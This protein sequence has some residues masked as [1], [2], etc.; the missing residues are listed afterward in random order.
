MRDIGATVAGRREWTTHVEMIPWPKTL[1]RDPSEVKVVAKR[2]GKGCAQL[3]SCRAH[4]F[5]R[6]DLRERRPGIWTRK[7]G[8]S[9]G[10]GW[11]KWVA[12]VCGQVAR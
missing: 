1:R 11:G 9:A 5:C 3:L 6:L 7:P 8:G 4:T 12:S 2:Q 10:R